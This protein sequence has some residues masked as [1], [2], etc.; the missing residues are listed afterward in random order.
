MYL[1]EVCVYL[2]ILISSRKVTKVLFPMTVT[3]IKTTIML[4]LLVVIVKEF[5]NLK[6]A[7]GVRDHNSPD[8]SEEALQY[9]FQLQI[10]GG[11]VY[12]EIGKLPEP[13]FQIKTA[14]DLILYKAGSEM[15]PGKK[16]NRNILFNSTAKIF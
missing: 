13:V 2:C 7:V 3:P 14:S 15:R 10:E 16:L 12:R 4:L 8:W 6:V 9:F 5:E 1:S 11:G